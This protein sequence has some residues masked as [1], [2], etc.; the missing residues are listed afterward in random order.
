MQMAGWLIAGVLMAGAASAAEKIELIADPTFQSGFIAKDREGKECPIRWEGSQKPLWSIAQHH[1]KSCFA[2]PSALKTRPGGCTLQDEFELLDA[3]PQSGAGDLVLGINAFKEYGGVYRKKGGIWPHL[4]VSQ[5]ISDPKG[6]LGAKSPVI[7]NLDRVELNI[8]FRLLYNHSHSNADFNVHVHAAQ[9]IFMFTIQ[10]LNRQS[11]GYGDYY[12]FNV[13]L[14]DSRKKL[15]ALFAMQDKSSAEKKGTEK[16]IYDI[17]IAPFTSAVVA[18]GQ[19][20][21][22]RGDLLPHI[23]QGLQEAWKRGFLPVSQNEA[24][25]RIASLVMGWEIPGL[26]DAAFAVKN[27]RAT[28]TLKP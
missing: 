9:F 20:V 19:W 14:F 16:L 6:H 12:W 25:Y 27:L 15:T 10:N 22:V 7:A 26:N 2:E 8:D 24:D 28:A 3:H 18:D 5:R 4:Y 13:C 23:R 1:S 11:K 21:N 17:G